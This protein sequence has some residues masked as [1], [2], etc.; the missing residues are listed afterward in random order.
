M[1]ELVSGEGGGLPNDLKFY[2]FYGRCPLLL[3]V[4]RGDETRF[5]W[6]TKDG[7]VLDARR[8]SAG[9]F[10]GNGAPQELW[11][12]A[13]EASCKIPTPFVRIDF[14][15]GGARTVFGEFT[16]RTGG[17]SRFY[18]DTDRRLGQCFIEAEARLFRDLV[19]GKTSFDEFNSVRGMSEQ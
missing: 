14:L 3:E 17:F 7:N 18:L 1:E 10:V 8:A 6:W 2:C 13:S 4:S 16:P 11:K 15:R 5:C 12:M 9:H 19:E